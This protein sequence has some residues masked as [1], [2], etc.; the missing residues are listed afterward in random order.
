MSRSEEKELKKAAWAHVTAFDWRLGWLKV[1]SKKPQV[2][3][4]TV[5]HWSRPPV[6]VFHFHFDHT[7]D[8]SLYQPHYNVTDLSV[9]TFIFTLGLLVIRPF[10]M[11]RP[12]DP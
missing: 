5:S 12:P 8:F 10:I 1:D 2:N 7:H 9:N 4:A 6:L 11:L 3:T